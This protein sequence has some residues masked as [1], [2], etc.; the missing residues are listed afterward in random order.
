MLK[1]HRLISIVFISIFVLII[2]NVIMSLFIPIFI[3]YD[4]IE[5]EN[6]LRMKKRGKQLG[7][8][9]KMLLWVCPCCSR[10]KKKTEEKENVSNIS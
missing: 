7:I 4:R 2:R 9:K 8:C 3:E 1:S 5:K 10:P 6:Y